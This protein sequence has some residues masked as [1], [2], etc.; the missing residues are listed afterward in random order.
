MRALLT[1]ASSFT[2]FWFAS[3]L[4]AAGFEVIAPLRRR[5]EQYEGVRGVRA[6]KLAAVATIVPDCAFGSPAFLDVVSRGRFDVLCHH[7]ARVTDYRS[8]SFDIV[9]ALAENTNNLVGV[10]PNPFGPFEEARFCA[11][12]VSVAKLYFAA[13]DRDFPAENYLM[14]TWRAGE[15]AECRVPAYLRDN[16]HVD[17]L[18][19]AYADYVMKVLQGTHAEKFGPMG[20][21]ETQGAFTE[22][23][24][25]EIRPRLG[26]QCA[27]RLP[28]RTD[29]SEPLA[30]IN[31][32][33]LDAVALGW[34][35]SAAWDAVAKFYR[36]RL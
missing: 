3:T 25:R 28:R 36:E 19:L 24:A 30:R 8:P 26:W 14:K 11:Y 27:V 35:E 10:I 21:V 15:T 33:A 23:Y 31:T 7:A 4:R 2:G 5:P 13:Q 16:I 20:Y 22:R 18:A 17:L 6:R 1:G 34:S 9:G 32:H 12:L 29:F